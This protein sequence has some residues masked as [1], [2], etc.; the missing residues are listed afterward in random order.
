MKTIFY[1]QSKR[2]AKSA[3]E[4]SQF[5]QALE[6]PTISERDG[7]RK[8]AQGIVEE[9]YHLLRPEPGWR[10]EI[11]RVNKIKKVNTYYNIFCLCEII[12]CVRPQVF[13]CNIS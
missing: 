9:G 11:L 12:L 2:S 5:V 3:H 10:G 4:E 7:T 6:D 8:H 13:G 1:F